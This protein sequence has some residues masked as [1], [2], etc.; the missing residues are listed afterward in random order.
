M[1][2]PFLITTQE[3]KH[4]TREIKSNKNKKLK[5]NKK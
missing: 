3:Q 5:T 2:M 4:E 1:G